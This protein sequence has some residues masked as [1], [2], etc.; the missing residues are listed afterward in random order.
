MP[1]FIHGLVTSRSAMAMDGHD[2]ACAEWAPQGWQPPRVPGRYVLTPLLLIAM[3]AAAGVEL[4]HGGTISADLA[5]LRR[6]QAEERWIQVDSLATDL[7]PR[8]EREPG[9]DSSALAEALYDFAR[10]RDQLGNYADGRALQ[11]IGRCLGIQIRHLGPDDLEV[12]KSQELC[13]GLLMVVNPDS[14]WVHC[15]RMLD[16]RTRKLAAD[17]TLMADTWIAIGGTEGFRKHPRAKLEAFQRALAV[18]VHAFGWE[19]PRTASTLGYVGDAWYD[20]GDP[21]SARVIAERAFALLQRNTKPGDPRRGKP[22]GTLVAIYRDAGDVSHALDL[23]RLDV[24]LETESRDDSLNL[25]I[26]EYN[27]GIILNEFGDNVGAR[28]VFAEVL[29]NAERTF[30]VT[31]PTTIAIRFA[32]ALVCAGV[33][34]TIQAGRLLREVETVLT[35]QGGSPVVNL[36]AVMQK[37][38]ELLH[39]QKRDREALATC[40]RA[41]AVEQAAA[42]PSGSQLTAVEQLRIRILDAMGDTTGLERVAREL[43]DI[44]DRYGVVSTGNAFRVAFWLAWAARGSGHVAEA[45]PLALEAQRR[46]RDQQ[47]LNVR[48]L[49]DVRA[50]ELARKWAYVLDQVIALAGGADTTRWE[51]AWD[52]LVRSRGLVRAELSRRRLSPELRSDTAMVGTH[53]RWVEANRRLA[54]RMVRTAGSKADS[55]AR[56]ALEQVRT[57]AELADAAYARALEGHGRREA[58]AEVGLADVRSRLRTGQALVSVAEYRF[59]EDPPRLMAFVTRGGASGIARVD[60]GP[61]DSAQ[62]LIAPWRERLATSPGPRAAAGGDAEG[63]CR[64]YGRDVRARIWDPIAARLTGAKE[65]YVVPDGPLLDLPWQAL[66]EGADAYLVESGP[67]IVP[68][69][70]ERDLLAPDRAAGSGSLLALGAPDFE[71]ADRGSAPAE[72]LLAASLRASGDPCGA[73]RPAA[74]APLPGTGVEASAIARRWRAERGHDATLLLGAEATESA[75]MRSAPGRTVLHLAT[76]GVVIGDT[77]LAGIPGTRGVGGIGT[78]EGRSHQQPAASASAPPSSSPS[79]WL[80]RRVW[81]ALAGSNHPERSDRG[82]DGLLTAEEVITLDL[83]GTDWVVLSACHSGVGE[84]WTHE[85]AL[86]MRRAFAMAGARSVISSQW[87]IEDAAANEWMQALYTARAAGT[88]QAAAAVRAASRAVLAARRGAGHSTHP[89]YWASFTASGE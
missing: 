44:R 7:L 67:L 18:R 32:L 24:K 71:Q 19:H 58:P 61:S 14:A 41:L 4:A 37:Q 52:Q 23:A 50:L 88:A 68:L 53:A 26:T 6:L 66:P 49:P 20:Q 84:N 79:P 9:A 80:G 86:G 63:E 73:G 12:A 56:A 35:A 83:T 82:D 72:P 89:F 57:Q 40:E 39:G 3:L 77:C 13:C 59:R 28:A 55:A 17:D 33:G 74:F 16:I 31:H 34:D 78:V 21:D 62:A 60:L 22:L 69:E 29:P 43:A 11:A 38:A 48:T 65:I 25:L 30:G 70:A 36:S 45:W 46:A 27:V 2:R 87:A 15:S 85:G 10:A 42:R 5:T 81:L 76:H 75:F 47:Q 51:V 8:V 1:R 54:S 64:R